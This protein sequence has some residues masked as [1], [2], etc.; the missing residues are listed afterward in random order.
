MDTKPTEPQLKSVCFSYDHSFGLQSPEVRETMIERAKVWWQIVES[1]KIELA[2]TQEC[3]DSVIAMMAEPPSCLF[4]AKNWVM[5]V[6]K[7]ITEPSYFSKNPSM[8]D[9]FLVGT[10]DDNIETQMMSLF[11]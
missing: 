8:M 4:E 1:A 7:E 10:E 3:V 9:H 5:A 6:I 11:K 2:Q